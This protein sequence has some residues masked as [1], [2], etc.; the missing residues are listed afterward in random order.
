M[1]IVLFA[2]RFHPSLCHNHNA[3]VHSWC[4]ARARLCQSRV[5]SSTLRVG[6]GKSFAEAARSQLQTVWDCIGDLVVVRL[7]AKRK[8]AIQRD[9]IKSRGYFGWCLQRTVWWL[10]CVRC[11]VCIVLSE[12][13]DTTAK[14]NKQKAGQQ[15]VVGFSL[16]RY[17]SWDSIVP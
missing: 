7:D 2:H 14:H 10:L 3:I 4:P 11:R 8:K 6:A 16:S 17:I 1:R 9:V 13:V 12:S 5:C 15:C